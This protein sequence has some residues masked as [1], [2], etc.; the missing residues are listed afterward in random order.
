MTET[1][2]ERTNLVLELKVNRGISLS[3][4]VDECYLSGHRIK[5]D[6]LI[7]K[8]DINLNYIF[9]INLDST[10]RFPIRVKYDEVYAAIDGG[11]LDIIGVEFP[12]KAIIA[13]DD[14]SENDKS[15]VNTRYEVIEPLLTDLEATLMNDYGENRFKKVIDDTGRSKQYVYDCFIGYLYYG[16]RRSGLAL[17]LGKNI[18]YMPKETREIRVKQGRPN[19]YSSKGKVLNKFDYANFEKAKRLYLKRNGPTLIRVF[20]MMLAKHYFESR[21]KI[22]LHE[23]RKTKQQYRI[24]L[25]PETECPTFAQF[26]YWLQ[27]QYGD[28]LA[29]R[30]KSR[31]NPTEF[32]K[33]LAGRTGNAYESIIAFGQVFELDETPFDEELVS[34]FDP[35]RRTKIGKATLY[36]VIDTFSK[37]IPGIY[38]TTENPSY[39]TVRQALFISGMDKT[40]FI[41]QYG[42]D[43]SVIIWDRYGVSNNFFVDNAEFRNRISEGAVFDLQTI[44]K[45]ARAGHGDDKPNVEQLF[46]LFSQYFEGL[47][48][49]H[50]TKSLTDIYSQIAR[51]NAS[52]TINELYVIAIVYINYH[53]NYRRIKEYSFDRAMIQDDVEPIPARIVEW[54]LRYRPGYTIHYEPEELYLKLLAKDTVSVGQKGILFPRAGLRYNCE[55]LFINGYQDQKTSRNKVRYFDCRFNENFLDIILI[56]TKEGLKIAT[57]DSSCDAYSGL[58]L[59]EIILQKEVEKTNDADAVHT[60]REYKLGLLDFMESIIKNTQKERQSTPMPNISTIKDNRGLEAM[61]NQFSDT[62]QFLQALNQNAILHFEEG[63][64]LDTSEDDVDEARDAFNNDED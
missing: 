49:A 17:P 52:L 28:L 22:S 30:D 56:C 60:Q 15:K 26:Y 40:K 37:Y 39:K 32:S 20:E 43:P 53:N 10:P 12:A 48:K 31:K 59:H 38:I 25:K 63:D 16:Q 9:L 1:S 51:K 2:F 27:T 7:V 35:T 62:N 42:L 54:S 33:D 4:E 34:V 44:V 19:K 47:S 57:L 61:L 64:N 3:K 5:Q 21:I 6:Y 18:F 41:E 46:R 14:L 45:F 36:F 50:Q 23:Q 55:W 24:K 13:F 29:K 11:T 58:S 8:L